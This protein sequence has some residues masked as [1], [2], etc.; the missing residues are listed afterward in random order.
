MYV[1]SDRDLEKLLE[2]LFL[3]DDEDLV[4]LEWP[5]KI[6]PFGSCCS[7]SYSSY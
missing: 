7:N 5:G 3:D 2:D 6:R 1:L 4:V